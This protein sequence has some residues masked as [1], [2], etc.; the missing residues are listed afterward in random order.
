MA[1]SHWSFK[2]LDSPKCQL[3]FIIYN[4]SDEADIKLFKSN[5]ILKIRINI[6]LDIRISI[7]LFAICLKRKQ[8]FRFHNIHIKL[9]ALIV[10]LIAISFAHNANSTVNLWMPHWGILRSAY[11]SMTPWQMV[12]GAIGYINAGEGMHADGRQRAAIENE[13]KGRQRRDI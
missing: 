2:K 13:A 7:T 1:V 9:Y 4:L 8:L 11:G 5:I 12:R 3:S 6:I 10:F